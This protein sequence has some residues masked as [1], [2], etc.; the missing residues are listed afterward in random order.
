MA[1]PK[2]IKVTLNRSVLGHPDKHR[3]I[4]R[5]LGLKK[6]GRSVVHFDVPTIRGMVNK[7]SHLLLVEDVVD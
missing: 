3:R 5:A 6:T 7:I 2:K 1:L 4:V